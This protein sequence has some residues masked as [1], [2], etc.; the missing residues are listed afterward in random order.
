MILASG[1]VFL[2]IDFFKTNF[3]GQRKKN[4]TRLHE[5]ADDLADDAASF[6]RLA[7]YV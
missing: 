7:L 3:L 6:Y 5:S 1:V 4:R 2:I